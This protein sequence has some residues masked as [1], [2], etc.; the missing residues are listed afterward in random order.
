MKRS[1]A[2]FKLAVRYCK[3]HVDKMRTDACA[4]SLL[5]KMLLNS[6][7]VC[8]KL[9]II[10][11]HVILSALVVS[12]AHKMSVMWKEHFKNMYN[13]RTE[14]TSR[15]LFEEKMGNCLLNGGDCY[16]SVIDVI[17]A[18]NSQKHNKAPEPDGLLWRPL[19]IHTYI[20]VCIKASIIVHLAQ[21]LCYAFDYW[22]LLCLVVKG[23]M[24]T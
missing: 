24:C 22:C 23:S 20:H 8:T 5:I 16:I 9:V 17:S 7:T 1:R 4:D 15:V 11:Q 10:K 21:E 13:S 3:D 18:V 14:S 19:Y 12:V 2:V 6:G